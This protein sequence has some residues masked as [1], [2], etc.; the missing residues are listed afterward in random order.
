M[1]GTFGSSLHSVL[2]VTVIIHCR[3]LKKVLFWDGLSWQKKKIIYKFVKI[4]QVV[5]EF[6]L[7]RWADTY[8]AHNSITSLLSHEEEIQAKYCITRILRD[9]SRIT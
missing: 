5:Q 3:K 6:K 7:C 8:R 1:K 4:G 9:V 2:V